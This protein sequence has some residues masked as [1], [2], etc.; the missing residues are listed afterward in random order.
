[1][2]TAQFYCRF[3]SKPLICW[4]WVNFTLPEAVLRAEMVSN[5]MLL[6]TVVFGGVL[7][8]GGGVWE[9]LRSVHVMNS[10]SP[11]P[12]CYNTVQQRFTL[13]ANEQ[14]ISLSPCASALGWIVESVEGA[15]L[16]LSYV[17]LPLCTCIHVFIKHTISSLCSPWTRWRQQALE[18]YVSDHMVTI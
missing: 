16:W 17:C 18:W 12:V 6:I 7:R 5:V 15:R 13:R 9:R 8:V 1:M 2:S 3:N 4:C 10:T 11:Q 14:Q